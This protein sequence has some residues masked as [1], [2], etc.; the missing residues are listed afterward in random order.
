[1]VAKPL[2]SVG[3]YDLGRLKGRWVVTWRE[4]QRRRR[5]RLP[6]A[7]GASLADGRQA[8][9]TWVRA[10]TRALPKGTTTVE[11]LLR[12]YIADRKQDGKSVVKQ[13][14]SWK[15]LEPYFGRLNPGDIDKAL[16]HSFRDARLKQGRKIGTVHTDLAVL[17]AG[18]GW[19]RKARMI[20]AVPHVW[21]PS[22]PPSREV[23]LT[24]VD[25][26]ALM[27]GADMPHVRLFIVLAIAT[28]ARA[29][30]ILTL[31]WDRCDF[32]RGMI[33]LKDPA[34]ARNAKGRATVPMNRTAR[35]ALQEARAGAI[36]DYVI[37]WNGRPVSSI[38]TGFHA[39]RRRA[40][41]TDVTPHDLRRTAGR[42][43]VEAG[44]PMAEVSQYMG[45]ASE[46]ITSKIYARFS[47]DYLRGAAAALELEPLTDPFSARRSRP[48]R[49]S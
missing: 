39:A 36:S 21:L 48:G 28:A 20:P 19:A 23:W 34:R 18:L 15:A 7:S 30:A 49:R 33:E 44:V 6:L 10:R 47:P 13:E 40:G 14:A 8:L 5:Y 26:E 41:L 4:G 3:G 17:R 25:V 2:H 24:R 12:A 22:A 37:E 11:T 46:T 29:E 27:A 9:E 32:D 35:A 38:K 16:C 45:H 1:M 31:T 43:M 42:W